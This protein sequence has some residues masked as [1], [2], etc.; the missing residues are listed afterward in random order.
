MKLRIFL[1]TLPLWIL[2]AIFAN[3]ALSDLVY[4]SSKSYSEGD[5]VIPSSTDFTLYTAKITV[6]AG[7]NG[8]PNST[9]WLTAEEKSTELANTHSDT[10]STP[11]SSDSIDTSEISNLGTP[12]TGDAGGIDSSAIQI[13]SLSTRTA[14]YGNDISASLN[15][16][17]DANTPKKV[18]FRV[19]GPS[20][21]FNGAKLANPWMDVWTRSNVQGSSWSRMFS[22]YDFGDHS[23][24]SEYESRSTGNPVEPLVVESITPSIVSCVINSE[25][26]GGTGNANVEVYSLDDD[27]TTS[28]FKSLST[29][30]YVTTDTMIGSL[31]LVGTGTKDI[32]FRV[33]GPSMNFSGTKLADPN[34]AIYHKEN[35]WA[36]IVKSSTFQQYDSQDSSYTNVTS[37]YADRHTGNNL[38]PLVVYRLS[39]GTYSCV[40]SSD[41]ANEEGSA[42]LEIY[43]VSE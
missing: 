24:S 14:I 41:I 36:E 32:M 17:G 33:K 12:D 11:P 2:G 37:S 26:D 13:F 42:N 23:S 7:S 10:V 3:S 1:T 18:M 16:G 15:M 19:K 21:N 30:G 40:V 31:R 25:T 27:N 28:Y 8:P 39:A 6:P 22:S 38:E 20:M 5:A 9:Y 4:D 34:L 35:G 29:R 43:D